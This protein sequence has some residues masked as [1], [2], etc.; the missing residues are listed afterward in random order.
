MK[1][2][3]D[4][5][6]PSNR[7]YLGKLLKKAGRST[8]HKQ[9]DSAELFANQIAELNAA[10]LS[11]LENLLYFHQTVSNQQ[12]SSQSNLAQ[13]TNLIFSLLNLLHLQPQPESQDTGFGQ[14]SL[15]EEQLVSEGLVDK[16]ALM[17]MSLQDLE[18]MVDGLRT[19]LEVRASFVNEQEEELSFHRQTLEE[20]QRK[21]PHSS[22]YQR[23]IWEVDLESEQQ[24][25]DLLDATLIGQRQRIQAEQQL[26]QIHQDILRYRQES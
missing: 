26:L 25:Y 15:S 10:Q 13:V 8:E 14:P 19:R 3:L 4:Q 23:M 2:F 18:V 17:Q 6:S 7:Y 11:Q 21:I 24:N 9:K 16:Q 12:A 5:L 22:E 1:S 20:L